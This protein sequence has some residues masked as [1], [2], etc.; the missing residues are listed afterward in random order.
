MTRAA[1][2]A[3]ACVLALGASGCAQVQ[4][5]A[6]DPAQ[7]A[8]LRR[9]L[10]VPMPEDTHGVATLFVA[11][12]RA[13]GIDASVGADASAGAQT[14]ALLFYQ[15]KW[16]WDMT[17]YMV[18]L[19]AQLRDPETRAVLASTQSYRPSLQRVLP[20]KMVHEVNDALFG[21]GASTAPA[22]K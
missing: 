9:V 13:R 20:A 5:R 18:S 15:S 10:V 2:F 14:D 17:E 21:A 12:L 6:L 22:A 19:D 1:A 7:R 8:S 16:W 11:D 4:G 3:A